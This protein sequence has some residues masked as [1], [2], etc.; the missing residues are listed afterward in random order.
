MSWA[1][2]GTV[3]LAAFLASLV[4]FVEA[5]TIVLAVGTTRGW[6]SALIGAGAGALFLTGLTLAV[7]PALQRISLT[8]LQLVV[9]VLLLLF[10]MR[11][12][13]KAILRAGAVIGLHD[14]AAIYAKETAALVRDG[15]GTPALRPRLDRVALATS[16]KAVTLEGLEVIFIVIATGARGLLM[17]AAVGAALAG[18]LVILAGLALRRPLARVPE[19]A[20]KFAVGAL[21]SAFGVFW[22]GEGL[23]YPWPGADLALLGLAGGFTLIALLAVVAVR[24][25]APDAL[26]VRLGTH[27]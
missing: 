16:F 12:L 7:G 19:N 4:E 13:R 5:L 1:H 3:I 17:P 26:P 6:R 18:S 21:L 27:P 22:V 11:W 2:A 23:G 14:E 24:G 9:G 25:P 15:G 10:G 8:S 20:L